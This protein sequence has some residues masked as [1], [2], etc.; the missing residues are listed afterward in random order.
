MM[1][2]KCSKSTVVICHMDS[3]TEMRNKV[4]PTVQ[5]TP[6]NPTTD[7][8]CHALVTRHWVWIDNWIYWTHMTFNY[9]EL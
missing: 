1:A 2:T 8:S 7:A 3:K 9:K 6:I 5:S 4:S